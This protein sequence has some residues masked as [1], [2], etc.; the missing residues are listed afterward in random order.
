MSSV[1]AV[2]TGGV[3]GWPRFPPNLFAIP[4]GLSGLL[5]A[6]QRATPVLGTPQAVPDAL[7]VVAALAWL[8][9]LSCYAAQGTRRCF[10]DLRDKTFSPFVSLAPVTGMLL[11][12]VLAVHAFALGRVLV[13]LFLVL[14]LLAPG[15]VDDPEPA[16]LPPRAARAAAA[17]AG[18]RARAAGRGGHRLLRA[19]R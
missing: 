3:R 17:H 12:A 7:A 4:F 11:A 14:T 9:L 2:V 13:V 16:V 1:Q 8:T 5:E 15:G 19:D 10:A 18:D 6:W